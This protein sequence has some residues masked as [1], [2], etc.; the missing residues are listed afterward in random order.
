MTSLPCSSLQ[1]WLLAP[2]APPSCK[3][4][5]VPGDEPWGNRGTGMSLLQEALEKPIPF[6][7]LPDMGQTPPAPSL[8]S[9]AAPGPAILR[10]DRFFK[11]FPFS[12]RS[13]EQRWAQGLLPS[14]SI[15][16]SQTSPTRAALFLEAIKPS[17]GQRYF[18]GDILQSLSCSPACWVL[19]PP[20][21]LNLVTKGWLD[22]SRAIAAE[23]KTSAQVLSPRRGQDVPAAAGPAGDSPLGA[24]RL[25]PASPPGPRCNRPSSASSPRRLGRRA[26]TSW[27]IRWLFRNSHLRRETR[28]FWHIQENQTQSEH[29]EGGETREQVLVLQRVSQ[30]GQIPWS[31]DICSHKGKIKSPMSSPASKNHVSRHRGSCLGSFLAW[32]TS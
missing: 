16:L 27:R 28:L 17:L 7:A 21:P 23:P 24:G 30:V 2:L 22:Q 32:Q 19:C 6:P 1:P 8:T 11:Q 3:N 12:Y 9:Q 10:P 31:K 25:L 29:G 5:L 13:L 26:N 4:I 20:V 18:P 14:L 15:C